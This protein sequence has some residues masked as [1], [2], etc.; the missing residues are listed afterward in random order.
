MLFQSLGN[1][2]QRGG[3]VMEPTLGFRFVD[4]NNL[5]MSL[6]IEKTGSLFCMNA[7]SELISNR[8]KLVPS[9]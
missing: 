3:N 5:K 2:A 8:R 4:F 6:T 1:V 7:V 9:S